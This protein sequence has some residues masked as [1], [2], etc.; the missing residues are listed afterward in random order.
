MKKLSMNWRIIMKKTISIVVTVF[1][2]LAIFTGCSKTE[3][4][5]KELTD[6]QLGLM[7]GTSH[8]FGFV[9]V[10]EGFFQE[11]GLNVTLTTFSSTGELV[12]GVESGRLDAAFIGSTGTVTNQAAGHNITVFGG[13]MTNGILPVL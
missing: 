5:A 4:K 1:V 6:F 8:L 10:E 13:A 12:A 3:K 7:L 11:E 2:L 9:A